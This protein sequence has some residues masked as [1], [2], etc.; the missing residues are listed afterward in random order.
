VYYAGC[1]ELAWD[2]G[3]AAEAAGRV[4]MVLSVAVYI[5]VCGAFGASFIVASSGGG[6][7]IHL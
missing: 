6:Q 3:D 5:S 4:V 7:L 1:E 2:G